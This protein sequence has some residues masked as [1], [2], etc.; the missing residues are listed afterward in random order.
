MKV[1][2]LVAAFQ[3]FASAR[4]EAERAAPQR[5]DIVPGPQEI[6]AEAA[7]TRPPDTEDLISLSPEAVFTFA[8]SRFDPERISRRD[9]GSLIDTLHDGGAISGRDRAILESPP[10]GGPIPAIVESDPTQPTNL[11]SEFQGRLATDLANA[12]VRAVEEDTRA[13]AILGR[14]ASIRE[15]LGA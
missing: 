6:K 15:E 2:E 10:R 4:N 13:L 11:V 9:L 8:A 5:L 12:N 14:L 1:A 7:E 3:R